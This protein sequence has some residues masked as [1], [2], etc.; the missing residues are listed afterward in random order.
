MSPACQSRHTW[1]NKPPLRHLEVKWFECKYKQ[2][3]KSMLNRHAAHLVRCLELNPSR[4]A[5][6]LVR[7][8]K[9][10]PIVH[11]RFRWSYQNNLTD[12]KIVFGVLTTPVPCESRLEPSTAPRG[13]LLFIISFICQK[14]NYIGFTHCLTYHTFCPRALSSYLQNKMPCVVLFKLV[15]C[16]WCQ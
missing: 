14:S 12:E 6:M 9:P 3:N 16:Y 1:L 7:K 8:R 11:W 10:N 2:T 13:D 4:R 5:A 15:C